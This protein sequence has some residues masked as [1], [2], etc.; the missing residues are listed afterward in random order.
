M[1]A[2][3][4]Q[5]R[6]QANQFLDYVT[7]DAV[8]QVIG[9]DLPLIGEAL[10]DKFVEPGV[11]TLLSDVRTAINDALDTVDGAGATLAQQ[12]AGKLNGL[13]GVV[14]A[15][16]VGEKV[17][18][19]IAA[20]DTLAKLTGADFDLDIGWDALGL[21]LKG[22]VSAG[23][24]YALDAQLTFD[25]GTGALTLVD[26]EDKLVTVTLD[27][28]LDGVAGTGDLG[29]IGVSVVDQMTGK[30]ISVTGTVDY[31]APGGSIL[32][33]QLGSVAA[34][35]FQLTLKGTAQTDLALTADLSTD[36]LPKIST[37]LLAK[38]AFD[39]DSANDDGFVTAT[40]IDLNDITLDV[41]SIVG[42]LGDVF[43]PIIDNVF[44]AFPIKQ[45][46]NTVTAPLPLISD[47]AEKI[48]I[49]D[50]LNVID[51]DRIN[52]LD[53]A[54]AY[55]KSTGASTEAIEAFSKAYSL[56]QAIDGLEAAAGTSSVINLG[57][58][59]VY[60][61][62]LP[63]MAALPAGFADAIM[64]LAD[65]NPLSTLG[66]ALNAAKNNVP[67]GD[68]LGSPAGALSEIL[69]GSGLEL[70]ILQ[71]ETI[72]K[73]LTAGTSD[74][75]VDLVKYDIPALAFDAN[76]HK[77]FPV[78][79]PIGVAFDGGFG[80]KL[81]VDIG[82]DSRG[83]MK[84][85]GSLADGFY[86]TTEKI[87]DVFAP[88]GHV[89]AGIFASAAVN[90]G[91]GEAGVGGG[92]VAELNAYLEGADQPNST[93]KLY[94]TDLLTGSPC[95][96]D[97]ISGDFTVRVRAY[98]TVGV[99][100]FS[101]TKRFD[102][103]KKTLAD[104]SYGCPPPTM[105]ENKGL[106][107]LTVD[108]VIKINAGDR[109][110]LRAINGKDGEDIDETF[111]IGQ[112]ENGAL[113]LGA[114]GM[115]DINGHPGKKGD[116][117]DNIAPV[118]IIAA[119][120][121]GDDQMVLDENVL[122]PATLS[123]DIGEDLLGGGLGDDRLDGGD[124]SD[125]LLGRAGIDILKGGDGNDFLEGGEGADEIDGG[126]NFDQVT[127][128][129][130]TVG[131]VF[132]PIGKGRYAGTGG[133]AE[134]DVLISIEQITG[135]H[136]DDQLIGTP[137]DGN[138][139][140]G[141]DGADTLI[142][143]DRPDLL[144][145]GGGGDALQ[146]GGG[147]D[148]I[149]YL[150]SA[151]QVTVSLQLGFGVGG[152]ASG[153]T[154]NSIENVQGSAG[155][156]NLYGNA[157][158]NRLLG[159]YGDDTLAGAAGIDEI[160]A[161][162]GDD[163]V[164]AL[165]DGDTLNGDSD[166][167]KTGGNFYYPGTDL[168]S[169]EWATSGV[170][171][172]LATYK[173]D[174]SGTKLLAVTAGTA[175]HAA[176]DFFKDR[177]GVNSV[178]VDGTV[179]GN[180][181]F[182]NLTG[183]RFKDKLTADQQNNELRGL[184]GNDELYGLAG[185][186]VLIGGTGAD[187]L[188]GD[189]GRDLAD[190]AGSSAGVQVTLK[191]DVMGTGVGGDAQ[192]DQLS[193]IEDLR[194][195]RLADI[196]IGNSAD[197]RLNPGIA[198]DGNSD[199]VDGGAGSDTLILDWSQ[200]DIGKGITGGYSLVPATQ[201]VLYGNFSRQEAATTEVLDNVNFNNIERINVTGTGKAD[202]IIGGAGDDI[203]YGGE[204]NDAL[205]TGIGFAPTS[206]GPD[207]LAGG[208]NY[209]IVLAGG[210]ND[211]VAVNTGADGNL[212]LFG[213]TR[214][215]LIDGGAGL[216]LLNAS[217]TVALSDITLFFADRS[218]D[219]QGV[220][221]ASDDGSAIVNFERMGIVAT[222][223]GNDVLVQ[224]GR[225]A[226][227]FATGFGRDVV[228]AGTGKDVVDGGLDFVYGDE[229]TLSPSDDKKLVTYT[230]DFA[231]AF[232]S[233]G[234]V[235]EVDYREGTA[236]IRSLVQVVDT[237]Y[238][239][240]RTATEA[241]VAIATNN[242]YF[243]A[244]KDRIDFSNIESLTVL[245]TKF[246]DQI[247]GTNLTY[248]VNM[249]AGEAHALLASESARGD[250][251]LFGYAGN[252]VI[253]AGTGSDV[254][255]GGDGND[256]LLGTAWP[257]SRTLGVVDLGEIDR[258][259]GGSGRDVFL[260]GGTVVL[261]DDKL[262]DSQTG[263]R[264]V[265]SDNHAEIL[266]FNA[267]ED[268]LVLS[269]FPTE[270]TN[271]RPY[272]AY[273]VRVVDGDSYIY[274]R[275]G[276]ASGSN[277]AAANNELIAVIEGVS[278]FSLTAKSTLYMKTDG[279]YV[280]GSGAVAPAPAALALASPPPVAAAA[281]VPVLPDHAM[282]AFDADVTADVPRSDAATAP[283][284]TWVKQTADTEALKSALFKGSVFT[285][286]TLSVEGDGAAVGVFS[287]DP[288]GLG[289]GVV[290]STGRVLDLAGRNTIDGGRAS[291]GT[292]SLGFTYA[293]TITTTDGGTSRIYRA[294]LSELG[295]D[296]NSIKLG[297]ASGGFGGAPGAFSGFDID[298]VMLSREERNFAAGDADVFN[299]QMS[300]I[301][302]FQFNLGAV[303]YAQGAKRYPAQAY[304]SE[305]QGTQNGLPRLGQA[306]LGKVD[307]DHGVDGHSA[308]TLGEGGTIG[309]DLNQTVSTAKP[310]YLY[311]AEAGASGETLTTGLTASSSRLEASSDLSTDLGTP[312]LA[313]DT[314][315]L[316]YTFK[317]R[318]S[319]GSMPNTIG[320]DVVFFS[321]EFAEFAQQGF[322]DKFKV[323]LNGV[324]LARLSDGSFAS[325]DTLYAGNA[326]PGARNSIYELRTDTSSPDLIY[327]P[328]DTGPA[329]ERT[330]ADGFSQVLHLVGNIDP[331]RTN[332]LTIQVSDE[333]DAYLDSGILIRGGS[334][335]PSTTGT[336]TVSAPDRPI[337]EGQI[338]TATFAIDLP[339][340]SR[341]TNPV[342]VLFTPPEGIDLGRGAGNP[343]LIELE[344]GETSG[345]LSFAVLRDAIAGNSR[346]ETIGVTVRGLPGTTS[347]AP[348]VITVEDPV[349]TVS[350]WTIG[351]APENFDRADPGAWQRAW[352]HDGLT[353]THAPD[354][355]SAYSA[356]N[357]G[358][359]SPDQLSGSDILAGDLGVSGMAGSTT[360]SPQELGGTERL[361][362]A[363]T[364]ADVNAVTLH[365]S[366]IDRGD[367]AVVEFFDA[368]G[369][370]VD[371]QRSVSSTS[372]SVS[373]LDDVATMIV[374][375]AAGSFLID[376]IDV[377]ETVAGGPRGGDRIAFAA[378]DGVDP[379]AMMHY[380]FINL[381]N[382]LHNLALA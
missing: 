32:V 3:V 19:D 262:T 309:F 152:D 263:N 357:F 119:M 324:E 188:Y 17:T 101:Y 250:D 284:V 85:D 241:G 203:I 132:T 341:L 321:E 74:A 317:P 236:G 380:S 379:R 356:V 322:N 355:R 26:T 340:G 131:V 267:K 77:F 90:V 166:S 347:V 161:G 83:L 279:S 146:G 191:D 265:S 225:Y 296:L 234:D 362:F 157:A 197:N 141:L 219:F 14:T 372:L 128:E 304:G 9:A 350:D 117:D 55:L 249:R 226:N 98:V 365:F 342:S 120:G 339:E 206:T 136:F 173:Y 168:L 337:R 104:F 185:D 28:S 88:A 181:T 335:T 306:T 133:E 38:F 4:E 92:V 235:L 184:A 93:G 215:G 289:S 283:N 238:R 343:F 211:V 67:G 45:L 200:S 5:L 84:D 135:S 273:E 301:D 153:D 49:F 221:H 378:F 239:L 72:V 121:K 39:Y 34:D 348:I 91:V 258:L 164:Y 134:G 123:G 6:T 149:S 274:V 31:H 126:A 278:D 313:G 63:A 24:G 150:T 201:Q 319:D 247:F 76:F 47:G 331:T 186:D 307:G 71:L 224:R 165:G 159:W 205:L 42:F 326:G 199:H 48:G 297:D 35:D 82:Y 100:P 220:N 193:S 364:S 288:F 228:D 338:G 114:F 177:I 328:V 285:G 217:F 140:E 242:G 375:S 1:N 170:T 94:L 229:V 240:A 277:S 351:H 268:T 248:G 371:A 382:H 209:D 145:G 334:F 110:Y 233:D 346:V 15:T 218:S 336:F 286:G 316:T 367:A 359:A 29:F 169:Y 33:T 291:P 40:S 96:F 368:R 282:A 344:P 21:E 124:G 41:G 187:M 269:A 102:L 298:A 105:T 50:L 290:L 183:S 194:G 353:I 230:G 138:I 175:F 245:G 216:D 260:V 259:E 302:A 118:A 99:D 377:T 369:T 154:Y 54:G 202:T 107:T 246:A 103:V 130:S 125:R 275:D 142:G 62:V 7:I 25:V 22:G 370:L 280:Y 210:G 66:E 207:Y 195:T 160:Y 314:T 8:K 69:S 222:G 151:G 232:M 97:P 172:R 255:R 163:I 52:L 300:R 171:V 196:L 37:D 327:N 223:F 51:D 180:S 68:G 115:T 81:D 58:Q 20:N 112:L 79:G 57:S 354:V 261:Y 374:S 156:D 111:T 325:I 330:R 16:A 176:S 78:I 244:G 237:G 190:Y 87:N 61:P 23:M 13:G 312:G 129:N 158:S 323:M 27:G 174:L 178:A 256:V 64:A 366:L 293:G 308:L 80:A 109:A 270:G 363:F 113:L 214:F 345:S 303:E 373:G 11:N 75:P 179:F 281:K 208:I 212:S 116:K 361:K 333:G 352:S 251:V 30:E 106:G 108:N 252:D 266:D 143:G 227:V 89:E 95:I 53:L 192:G 231:Q 292:S 213:G 127:Y 2:T 299:H 253:F 65:P 44:G 294:N 257:V 305:L 272:T 360:R 137:G 332:T 155:N 10:I 276:V 56:I 243:E 12:I 43:G 122:A 148:T 70:P 358:I 315:T 36:L 198:R 144:I 318:T 73:L 167:S 329:A 147:S 139:L 162:G 59:H 376:A 264:K 287:G 86:F 381:D 271:R 311:V 349:A 204:G 18:I 189:D 254:V 295:F 310:L 182:E 46:L 60:G 320:F